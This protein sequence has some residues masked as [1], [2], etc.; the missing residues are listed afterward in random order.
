MGF[1][2]VSSVSVLP[3]FLGMLTDSTTLIGLVASLQLLGWQLP[4]LLTAQRVASLHLYRPMVMRMTF[5]ERWPFFALMI[6]ALIAPLVSPILAVALTFLMIGWHALG[7]GLTATPWQSML[8]K[9]IPEQVRGSFFGIHSAGFTLLSAVGAVIAGQFLGRIAY[10]VNFAA[11]F[12]LASLFMFASYF[13]LAATREFEH[14]P[15]AAEERAPLLA[16]LRTILRRDPNYRWFVAARFVGQFAL[17]LTNFLTVFAVRKA[18]AG[19]EVIGFMTS[20]MLFVQV[21]ANILGGWLGDRLGHQRVLALGALCVIGAALIPLFT[22][23][24]GWLY[25]VFALAGVGS[26]AFLT[27]VLAITVQFGEVHE[28]PYYIGLGNSVTAIGTLIAPIIGGAIVDSAGFSAM[29]ATAAAA[30]SIMVAL[31]LFV[32]SNPAQHPAEAA[33]AP[34]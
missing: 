5:E 4:Q 9:V 17:M 28:R 15:I 13:F 8:G 26:S 33:Q 7:A 30:G 12:L 24:I 27:S 25:V 2:F 21:P 34:G 19:P 29:F 20:L 1:G 18:G 31:L 14:T 3:L 6:V 10:P 23:A 22:S 11:C 32:V 16:N